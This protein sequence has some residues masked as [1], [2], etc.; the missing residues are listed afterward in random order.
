MSSYLA[1]TLHRI[2]SIN[3]TPCHY[4]NLVAMATGVKPLLFTPERVKK[5]CYCLHPERVKMGQGSR[6]AFVIYPLKES[7]WEKVQDGLL[8]FTP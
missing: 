8:L 6:W 7:E 4:G 3:H 1:W 2:I 5:G